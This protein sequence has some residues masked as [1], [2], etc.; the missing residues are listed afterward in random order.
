[1]IRIMHRLLFLP[2]L[3]V[4]C[5][6]GTYMRDFAKEVATQPKP[7]TS[8][9]GA[10]AGEWKSEVNGHE[11]PLWCMVHP[12]KEQPGHFDFRYRAGWGL[13]HFG[14]YVHTIAAVPD[15]AGNL[16]LEGKMALPAGMGVY[17]VKGELTPTEFK[18]TYK[19]K[20]DRGTMVL[21]RP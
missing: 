4:S 7:P 13:V 8:V 20:A 21:A 17:S 11:G 5:V 16:P 2:L 10:W 1:M 3:F 19:S 14:D 15:K 18:A 9:D 12:S 6:P